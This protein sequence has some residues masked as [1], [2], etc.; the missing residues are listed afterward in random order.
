MTNSRIRIVAALILTAGG[1]WIHELI[2]A[3][4]SGAL[5]VDTSLENA[6]PFLSWTIWIYFSFFLFIGTTVFRVED[7][8]FWQFVVSATLAACIAWT[9]VMLFPI[10]FERPDPSLIGNEIH[11]YVY[12]FV[13][14]ADPHHITF[15]SL[16]VGVTWICNF[17]LWNKPGRA[18]RV[19]LGIG[20]SLSTLTTKQHMLWDVLGGIVLAWFCVR[21]SRFIF[22][23]SRRS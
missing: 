5:D 22:S 1:L 7:E 8:L 2:Q 10:T 4:P 3:V 14:T 12:T 20:I 17:L 18:W 15:P 19:V 9:I 13:H 11:R 16:H 23:R 6:I 21:A